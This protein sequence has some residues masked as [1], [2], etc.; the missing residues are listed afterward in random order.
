MQFSPKVGKSLVKTIITSSISQ[1]FFLIALWLILK[2]NDVTITTPIIVCYLISFLAGALGKNMF[3][4]FTRVVQEDEDLKRAEHAEQLINQMDTYVRQSKELVAHS[5][6]LNDRVSM[7]SAYELIPDA[8]E[9]ELRERTSFEATLG[10]DFQQGK[11]RWQRTIEWIDE[12]ES[13]WGGSIFEGSD[14]EELRK[15]KADMLEDNRQSDVFDDTGEGK[16]LTVGQLMH[17]RTVFREAG[18]SLGG[19]VSLT[20][21]PVPYS[22]D[23]RRA[24]YHAITQDIENAAAN[25]TP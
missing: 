9:S 24:L 7:A 2:E 21:P 11:A 4:Q 3:T 8:E 17:A 13:S 22:K 25:M 15:L 6:R 19:H 18:Y 10:P 1:I 5:E 23:F 20:N 14:I 12:I 16:T